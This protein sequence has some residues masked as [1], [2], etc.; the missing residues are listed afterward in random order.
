MFIYDL[1]ILCVLTC[2]TLAAEQNDSCSPN[3]NTLSDSV[4]DYP[5]RIPRQVLEQL[6]NTLTNSK[7]L[8]KVWNYASI[9][10]KDELLKE[11]VRVTSVRICT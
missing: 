4:G 9:L 1:F 5:V 6:T 2:A 7:G 10:T 8:H 3:Q 11:K